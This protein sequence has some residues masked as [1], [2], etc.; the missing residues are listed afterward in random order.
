[1]I[2]I[3]KQPKP[4][5]FDV[6]VN[7]PGLAFLATTPH[8]TTRQWKSH[9]YWQKSLRS[10]YE[11]YHGICAYCGEWISPSTGDPVVDHFSPK[12]LH[13]KMAYE[14]DNYRLACLRFNSRKKDYE[15]VLDPFT[16][17]EAWFILDFPSLIVKANSALDSSQQQLVKATISRLQLNDE[18]CIESRIRWVEEFCEHLDYDFLSRRAP[19]IAYELGRQGLATRKAIIVVMKPHPKSMAYKRR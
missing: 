16:I 10:L 18:T 15:D 6:N 14:W 7:N 13:P 12:S 11:L 3:A 17:G 8:P 19:F 1:M 5:D 9:A 2:L 4:T